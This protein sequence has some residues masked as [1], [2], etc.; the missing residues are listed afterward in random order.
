MLEHGAEQLELEDDEGGHRKQD[1][2]HGVLDQAAKVPHQAAADGEDGGPGVDDQHGLALREALVE[3]AVVHVPA[4][5]LL[6][7][8][9]V[10]GAADNGTRRVDNGH[11][12]DHDGHCQRRDARETRRAHEA[13]DAKRRSQEQGAG[14]THKDARRVEIVEEEGDAHGDEHDGH[15]GRVV[16]HEGHRE[17]E[18]TAGADTGDAGS[19]AVEAVDE[20]DYVGEGHEVYD[21]DRV[22][23]PTQDDAA[24]PQRNLEAAHEHT[25][26]CDDDCGDD[27]AEELDAR[28]QGLDVVDDTHDHDE[29]DADH[30]AEHVHATALCKRERAGPDMRELEDVLDGKRREQARVHGHAAHAGNRFL[31]DAAR[32]RLVD[33]AVANRDRADDGNRGQGHT[34]GHGEEYEI[35]PPNKH[36]VGIID[37]CCGGDV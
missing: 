31:V 13:D 26:G 23:Q 25:R 11:A 19:K 20:V 12:R 32:T 27:L 4:V 14:V 22:G 34:K 8:L 30:H 7:G 9:V 3:Q 33:N 37:E 6:D 21:R 16:A 36:N 15:E 35:V 17:D 28:A 5:G 18:K 24:I 10:E 1:E 29:G 2:E